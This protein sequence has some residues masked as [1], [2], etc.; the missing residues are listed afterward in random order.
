MEGS[1]TDGSGAEGI[2]AAGV[3]SAGPC[4]TTSKSYGEYLGE[5][6]SVADAERLGLALA[7]E[8][9]HP[10]QPLALAS[11]SQ[12]AISTLRSLSKGAPPR[13][14]IEVRLKDALSRRTGE[15]GA[16]WV[17][18]HIGIASN[19]RADRKAN[20]T[21]VIGNAHGDP[22]LTT[23]EGLREKGRSRRADARTAPGFG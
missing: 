14:G 9:E 8:R 4:G 23:F 15:P 13:S 18:R 5:M 12:A 1:L 19:E 6:T 22:G 17:R 16:L 11:D 3:D 21:R 10:E 7:L 2:Q 20:L